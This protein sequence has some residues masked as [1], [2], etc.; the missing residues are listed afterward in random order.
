MLSSNHATVIR[1]GGMAA[2]A[3]IHHENHH[4]R[5]PTAQIKIV[6]LLAKMLHRNNF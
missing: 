5:P 2:N 1:E 4:P 6:H 3:L